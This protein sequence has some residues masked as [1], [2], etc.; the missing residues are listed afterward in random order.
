MNYSHLNRVRDARNVSLGIVSPDGREGMLEHAR[1]FSE[2]G[3]R[4]VFDP[5]QGMP[6][7]NGEELLALVRQASYVTVNDYEGRMLQ[8]R[9]G[10][11][12][13]QLAAAVQA[14]IVTQGAAGSTIYTGG[15]TLRIPSVKASAVVDPTGCGDAYRAG[16]LYG[17][18]QGYDWP[19][20]GRLAS[21]MGAIKIASRGGQNHR[22]TRD[23]IGARYRE[24]FGASIW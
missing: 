16:L 2:A 12:L 24:A 14:L 19:A 1:E 13:E 3:I 22:L 18:A 11:P 10:T 15:E 21:L 5:G 6:M 23:E 20:T 4:F 17:I 8:E 7:F 9:T